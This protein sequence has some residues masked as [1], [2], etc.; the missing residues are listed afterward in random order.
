MTA[1]RSMIRYVHHDAKLAGGRSRPLSCKKGRNRMDNVV[2]KEAVQ[3]A[4]RQAYRWQ[5]PRNWS[6]SQW[7]EELVGVADLAA[8]QAKHEYIPAHG[9]PLQA[10][11]LQRTLSALLT[12]YRREWRFAS[13]CYFPNDVAREGDE[14]DTE[15]IDPRDPDSDAF[16]EHVCRSEDVRRALLRLTDRERQVLVLVFWDGVSEREAAERLGV[17]LSTVCI[18]KDRALRKLRRAA[19]L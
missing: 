9:A 5:T 6:T 14:P 2:L 11:L 16:V 10:F 15:S 17:A 13:Q 8:I 3:N 19:V 1:N 18:Y 12:H 4:L 7:R